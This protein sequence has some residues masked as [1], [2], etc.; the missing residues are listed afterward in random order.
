MFTCEL[1]PSLTQDQLSTVFYNPA[2]HMVCPWQERIA[3]VP[4]EVGLLTVF[5]GW[6]EHA[7]PIVAPMPHGERRII[8]STDYF[9][10]MSSG[11]SS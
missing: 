8:V 5:P 3:L 11:F 7:A 9:P 6:I 10:D 2:A 1:P 4:P